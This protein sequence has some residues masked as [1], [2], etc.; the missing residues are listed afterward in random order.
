MIIFNTIIYRDG[1]PRTVRNSILWIFIASAFQR[2]WFRQSYVRPTFQEN[3]FLKLF[4]CST[5][6]AGFS[7]IYSRFQQTMLH[8]D[9]PDRAETCGL[10]RWWRYYMYSR[11]TVHKTGRLWPC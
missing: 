7:S 3:Y 4:S 8:I 9:Y 10:S 5:Y 1:R 2:H 11:P 6:D